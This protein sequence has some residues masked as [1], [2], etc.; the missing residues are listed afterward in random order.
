MPI[1]SPCLAGETTNTLMSYRFGP[2]P[3]DIWKQQQRCLFCTSHRVP[4]S[5]SPA[6]ADWAVCPHGAGLSSCWYGHDASHPSGSPASRSSRLF[7]LCYSVWCRHIVQGLICC[8]FLPFCFGRWSWN[9]CPLV[10]C[11]ILT[12]L[13]LTDTVPCYQM[14]KPRPEM[15]GRKNGTN[16]WLT[17]LIAFWGSFR[18]DKTHLR[19]HLASQSKPGLLLRGRLLLPCDLSRWVNLKV[20]AGN[21]QFW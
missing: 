14:R 2:S 5:E 7:T 11:L 21:G 15:P 18:G 3:G 9:S 8:C 6:F 19:R 16:L 20:S 17:S 10:S 13:L 4:P 1:P 12:F